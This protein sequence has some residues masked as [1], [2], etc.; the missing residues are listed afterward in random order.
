MS[1]AVALAMS[2]A[3]RTRD[4]WGQGAT[5]YPGTSNLLPNGGCYGTFGVKHFV[6]GGSHWAGSD[7]SEAYTY[8]TVAATWTSRAAH[9][10]G[11]VASLGG[12]AFNGIAVSLGGVSGATERNQQYHYSDASNTW[13]A[14]ASHPAA[15]CR[16]PQILPLQSSYYQTFGHYNGYTTEHYQYDP[17]ANTFTAKVAY[18]ITQYGAIGIGSQDNT[19]GVIAAGGHNGSILTRAVY[20]WDRVANAWTTKSI[21]A[22]GWFQSRA[23]D[24]NDGMGFF[25]GDNGLQQAFGAIDLDYFAT[26]NGAESYKVMDA[27]YPPLANASTLPQVSYINGTYWISSVN[28]GLMTKFTPRA[29]PRSLRRLAAMVAANA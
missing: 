7:R 25:F 21:L 9:P 5:T 22:Y 4:V 3:A 17:V 18:P 1:A 15:M 6:C 10:L 29:T 2:I 11:T 26:A 28:Q 12:A 8:D 23:G 24:A 27:Y 20:R 16:Y 19:D 14:K 13:T